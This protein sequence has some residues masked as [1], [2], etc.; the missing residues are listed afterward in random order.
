MAGGRDLTRRA[1]RW[2]DWLLCSSGLS[3]AG[4]LVWRVLLCDSE[5]NGL[6]FSAWVVVPRL[7]GV[8]ILPLLLVLAVVEK[9]AR[10]LVQ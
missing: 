3:C 7:L 5:P 10:R 1:P 6:P 2:L 9:A 4:Y 8:A